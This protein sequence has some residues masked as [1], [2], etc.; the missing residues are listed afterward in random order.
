MSRCAASPVISLHLNNPDVNKDQILPEDLSPK[1]SVATML[2]PPPFF[3]TSFF[4]L[5]WLRR[6]G[7]QLRGSKVHLRS[8]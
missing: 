4:S 2:I 1:A 6:I 8:G 7:S 3:F 5:R